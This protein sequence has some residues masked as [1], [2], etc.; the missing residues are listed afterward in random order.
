MQEQVFPVYLIAGFLDSGKTT[1]INGILAD[2]FAL[3][4]KTLLVCCEE[5]EVEY[6]NLHNVTVV[7]VDELEDLTPEFL[8]EEQ[9]K[10]GAT[11]IIVEFNGMWQIQH[12]YENSLPSN[13]ILYQIVVHVEG[14]TFEPYTKNI[15]SLMMKKLPNADMILVPRCDEAL[16][17]SLRQKNLRLVNRRADI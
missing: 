16:R 7:T 4:D 8:W 17:T 1:F 9:Q 10:C 13:W 11:Q 15:T 6:E 2:G 12:F 5:G 14:P 3:E